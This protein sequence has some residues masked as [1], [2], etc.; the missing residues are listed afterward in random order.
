MIVEERTV[1]VAGQAEAVRFFNYPYDALEEAVANAVYHKS[2]E[3]AKPIEI[4]IFPDSFQ[5][6]SF[7]GPVPPVTNIMLKQERV[8]ARDYRNRR[9]GDFLKELRLAEGRGTG[10]PLIRRKMRQNGSPEPRFETDAD[11]THFLAVLPIHPAWI[12]IGNQVSNQV[13]E[14][15]EYPVSPIT[16]KN[17]WG[18]LNR[19]VHDLSEGRKTLDSDNPTRYRPLVEFLEPDFAAILRAGV[20]PKSRKD[21]LEN[22]LHITNQ[23]KNA[24]RYIEPLL[25]A[26][27][28]ARTV[29]DRPNSSQQKYYT[30]ER[31]HLVLQLLE[32]SKP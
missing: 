2:Y 5:V 9:I 11:H 20:S 27:L 17:Y 1:K 6:L 21:I 19:F 7:P 31:G 18:L 12:L 3:E 30:T 15:D 14:Q 32:T 13:N 23:L 28:L 4:Q 25:E 24:S 22:T 29:P 26:K 10:L 16:G 8:I